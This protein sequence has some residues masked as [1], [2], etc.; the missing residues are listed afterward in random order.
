MGR[1]K[2]YHE[3][4]IYKRGDKVCEYIPYPNQEDGPF[5][6]GPRQRYVRRRG[7]FMG[8]VDSSM[9]YNS[10]VKTK[11]GIE[12]I[13]RRDLCF[14]QEFKM[15]F[16]DWLKTQKCIGDA[17][18]SGAKLGWDAAKVDIESALKE[19]YE[20]GF[21]AALEKAARLVWD[22]IDGR[23]PDIASHKGS[24]ALG[25]AVQEIEDE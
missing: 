11:L 18:V 6:D 25:N 9:S 8:N 4:H 7:I 3:D 10:Y 21:K 2:K 20:A 1:P 16:E 17:E 14:L 24:T 15:E 19:A 12:R 5:D 23:N 13:P 22:T